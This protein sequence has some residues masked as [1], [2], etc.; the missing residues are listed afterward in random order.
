MK[1]VTVLLILIGFVLFWSCNSE[2]KS[3]T[4]VQTKKTQVKAEIPANFSMIGNWTAD[5]NGQKL[6]IQNSHL[7]A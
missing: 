1:K 2:N 5:Y 3:N 7:C 6:T 4:G